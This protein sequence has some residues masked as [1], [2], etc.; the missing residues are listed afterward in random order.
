MSVVCLLAAAAA[1][2][3]AATTPLVRSGKF[4]GGG[5]SDIG[6]AGACAGLAGKRLWYGLKPGGKGNGAAAPRNI[7]NGFGVGVDIV[8]M[9]AVPADGLFVVAEV[10][11]GC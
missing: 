1:A 4:G 9:P 8:E 7:R 10:G 2:A 3:A 11:D 6:K 5:K